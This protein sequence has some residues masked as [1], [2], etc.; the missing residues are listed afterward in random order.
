VAD[1]F[2]SVQAVLT[3]KERKGEALA[4]FMDATRKMRQPFWDLKKNR[5]SWF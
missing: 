1:A 4:F 5:I 3:L 2:V